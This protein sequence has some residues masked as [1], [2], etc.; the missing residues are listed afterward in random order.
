MAI[1]S[2]QKSIFVICKEKF[3]FVP[4]LESLKSLI[5]PI[6]WELTYIPFISS[7]PESKSYDQLAIIGS[8]QMQTALIGVHAA[9]VDD[10]KRQIEMLEDDLRRGLAPRPACS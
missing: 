4:V 8:V 3:D 9:V 6:E 2:E 10:M 1:L 5:Y 7:D